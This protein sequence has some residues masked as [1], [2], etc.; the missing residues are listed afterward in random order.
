[1]VSVDNAVVAPDQ[2]S[3]E[4]AVTIA[5]QDRSGPFDYHLTRK[6]QGLCAELDIAHVRDVFHHYR[7]D[8]ATALEAGAEMRAALIG[9]GVDASHGYERTHLDGIRAVAELVAAYV[10]TPLTFAWDAKPRGPIEEYPAL[11]ETADE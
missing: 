1:M 8:I 10:Q 11:F 3:L 6:L 2:A 5:M 7:S 9:P 4:T